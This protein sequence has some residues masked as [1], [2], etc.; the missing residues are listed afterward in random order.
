METHQHSLKDYLTGLLLAAALTLIPFWVVWTGGWSTRAM[1]TTITACA[2]VQVLVHL[3]YF[4]NISVARTGKDYLSA[5]LFSGV[6]II[7]MV[8]GTIW[9]L[10]DLNFRMM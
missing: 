1:F 8:G 9:I 10:F 6:L 3:R 4:L 5:L 2:L 7:L